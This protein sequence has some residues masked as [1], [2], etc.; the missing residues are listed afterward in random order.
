MGP[1]RKPGMT[2]MDGAPKRLEDGTSVRQPSPHQGVTG[3]ILGNQ[4]KKPSWHQDKFLNL[5]QERGKRYLCAKIYFATGEWNLGPAERKVIYDTAAS[6]RCCLV[7]GHEVEVQCVGRADVRDDAEKNEELSKKR[8]FAV[9]SLLKHKLRHLK[10]WSLLSGIGLGER[11]SASAK[12][13]WDEDR[14]VEVFVRLI[15]GFDV[16]AR[17]NPWTKTRAEIFRRYYPRYALWPERGLEYLVVQYEEHDQSNY[18]VKIGSPDFDKVLD[19]VIKIA[20]PEDQKLISTWA[21]GEDRKAVIADAYCVEYRRAYA[22][23]FSRYQGSKEYGSL[24]P[25]ASGAP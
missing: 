21:Q 14:R 1:V 12:S 23:A 3:T 5:N 4:S 15:P 7:H 9:E 10:G 8:T 25:P 22:E 13:M 18:P 20:R 6:L 11:F 17:N 2:G 16:E 19:L 24:D